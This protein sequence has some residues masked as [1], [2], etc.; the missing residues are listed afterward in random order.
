MTEPLKERRSRAWEAVK[1]ASEA[2]RPQVYEGEYLPAALDV[3]RAHERRTDVLVL[4]TGTQPY[5]VALA[6]ALHP[7]AHVVLLHTEDSLRHARRAVDL[8]GVDRDT[9]RERPVAKAGS[10]EVYRAVSD[11]RRQFPDAVITVDITSGTKAMTAGAS[12]VAGHLVL[13]Q[14]YIETTAWVGRFGGLEEAHDVPNPL[15]VFGDARR[16]EAERAFADGRFEFAAGV[17]RELG[18]A[19]VPGYQWSAR[20][21][22]ADAY[23]AWDRLELG[24]AARLLGEAATS[25]RHTVALHAPGDGPLFAAR[26]RIEGQ[27]DAAR[28]LNGAFQRTARPAADAQQATLVL[29]YLLG[30]ARRA[31]PDLAALFS[32]RALELCAQRRLAVHGIDVANP[33]Y[34][35]AEALLVRYNA[36]VPERHHVAT[37]PA[38]L[39]LVQGW[40]LARA[41]PDPVV[42][43]CGT[44][45]L[46][47]AEKRNASVYAHG[48][49]AL[50]ERISTAFL[51]AVRPVALAV[52]AADDQEFPWPDDLFRPV[53]LTVR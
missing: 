18:T 42:V 16:V 39:G 34:P 45:A 23:A 4:P 13:P 20:E 36:L 27:A 41:L 17:F 7:A 11:V 47:H 35:D 30:R 38:K 44:A 52:A 19:A 8:A 2:D 15:V 10:A 28:T 33:L 51:E 46:D 14:S 5:S 9:V 32:Y 40:T 50:D 21:R 12:A 31:P 24:R 53:D 22:L 29:R 49:S 26:S 1:A 3:M 48:F 6:L 43:R 25:L 37:L